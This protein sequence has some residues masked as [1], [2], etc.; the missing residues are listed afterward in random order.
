MTK[1]GELA[2]VRSKNAGPFITTF[3]IFFS[4]AQSY[5]KVKELG[6]VTKERI[7]K[8]YRIPT[9]AVYGIN[10]ID[11]VMTIKVS[12]YKYGKKGYMSSGDPQNPD[13]FGAQQYI[14]LMSLEIP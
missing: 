9:E 7:A 2:K 12:V 3:D 11:G 14:P 1:L 8:L 10:F 13:H 5:N 6:F 4:D